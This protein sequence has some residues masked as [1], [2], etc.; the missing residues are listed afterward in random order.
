MCV[1]GGGGGVG[2]HLFLNLCGE[3]KLFT[4]SV[5]QTC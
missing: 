1:W 4:Q 5:D 3:N 2:L